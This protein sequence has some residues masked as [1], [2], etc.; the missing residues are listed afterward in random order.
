M[1]ENPDT[2]LKLLRLLADEE[3]YPSRLSPQDITSKLGVTKEEALLHIKCCVDSG[4]MDARILNAPTF[5]DPTRLLISPILGR[6]SKGQEFVRQADAGGGKW[7][8][9]A[10]E[11]CSQMG[12]EA[13]ISTLSQAMPRLIS[14]AI[15]SGNV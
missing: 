4:L 7:L 9:R 11:R 8:R 14:A 1:R 5:N 15:E 6:T 12:I 10:R 2:S 13:T 3:C